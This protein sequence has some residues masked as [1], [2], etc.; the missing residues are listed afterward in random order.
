[1]AA[2]KYKYDENL[3]ETAIKKLSSINYAVAVKDVATETNR[4]VTS[5]YDLVLGS[6]YAPVYD[7]KFNVN[8]T[9]VADIRNRFHTAENNTYVVD[10]N[11][12]LLYD[13]AWN[14]NADNKIVEKDGA[15]THVDAG[16]GYYE[17]NIGGKKQK[18]YYGGEK[19]QRN[20]NPFFSAKV[21][22]PFTVSLDYNDDEI[23]SGIYG[24]YVV[25]DAYRAVE[26]A[27]SEIEAWKSFLAGDGISGLNTITTDKKIEL[28]I[29]NKAANGDILGFRVYAVNYDGSLVDPDG[30]AFYVAVGEIKENILSTTWTPTY[31]ATKTKINMTSEPV[32]LTEDILKLLA[33]NDYHIDSNLTFDVENNPIVKIDNSNVQGEFGFELLDKDGKV[34]MNRYGNYTSGKSAKDATSIQLVMTKSEAKYYKN[35]GTYSAFFNI[36]TNKGTIAKKVTL[37]FTKVMPA[38][39]AIFSAKVNQFINGVHTTIPA[40]DNTNWTNAYDM[41]HAFNGLVDVEGVGAVDN[42]YKFVC[43]NE[44]IKFNGYAFSLPQGND[45][46]IA[47]A[48]EMIGKTYA[49]TVSYVYNNISSEYDEYDKYNWS[50]KAPADKNFKVKLDCAESL[51]AAWNKFN[52]KKEAIKFEI[53]Y[54][55]ADATLDFGASFDI[56]KFGKVYNILGLTGEMVKDL[57]LVSDGGLTD[58]YFT[59]SYDLVLSRLVFTPVVGARVPQKDVNSTLKFTLVDFFGHEKTVTLPY[60]V[61]KKP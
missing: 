26:S 11:K 9:K 57:H 28:T 30:K 4:Y 16:A 6:D 27:P 51:D 45:E 20:Y 42:N 58:E 47:K 61:V 25:Y 2:A 46:N 7:L 8:D 55:A 10:E 52:A 19:D 53:G 60:V 43:E 18:V 39:P 50:V 14:V 13:Y 49:V 12:D 32:A 36:M 34:V 48:F 24:F 35:N 37:K 31:D 1:M 59:V 33:D 56:K 38:F 29:N 54:A 3:S 40:Y 41:T 5:D 21:G 44:D 15:K 22:E 23:M 17:T